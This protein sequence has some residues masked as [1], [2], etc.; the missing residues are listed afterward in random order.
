L[1]DIIREVTKKCSRKAN[2]MNWRTRIF[3][4]ENDVIEGKTYGEVCDSIKKYNEENQTNESFIIEYYDSQNEW[5]EVDSLH[6]A[7]TGEIE[8]V[9]ASHMAVA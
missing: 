2:I 3:N 6:F 8:V 9:R 4:S 1:Y 5:I 7:D